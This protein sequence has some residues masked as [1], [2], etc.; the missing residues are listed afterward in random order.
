MDAGSRQW[1]LPSLEMVQGKPP[2]NSGL[3]TPAC[4]LIF[5]RLDYAQRTVDFYW[6]RPGDAG[7]VVGFGF[8][9]QQRGPD[10][11]VGHARGECFRLFCYRPVRHDHGPRGAMARAGVIASVFHVGHLW[12]LYHLLLL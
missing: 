8:Y 10:L 2:E 11:S 4:A 6:R 7:Q 1:G 9:R 5:A 12:W 3:I